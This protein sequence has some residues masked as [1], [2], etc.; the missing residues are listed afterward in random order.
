MARVLSITNIK[1]GVGKT[2]TAGNLAAA[3]AQRGRKV[4]AVDMDP[5]ASLTLSL[6]FQSDKLPRTMRHALDD[7]AVPLSSILLHTAEA[8]DL[9][10]ANHDL[11]RVTPLLERTRERLFSVRA[12]LA[13]V[14]DRYDYVLLDCPANAGVLTGAALVASDQ[15][16]VPLT[17]DFLSLRTLDWLLYIVD[18]IR[19]T[20]NPSL[21]IAGC[22]VTMYDPRPRHA[23]VVLDTLRT[24]YGA[25]MPVLATRIRYS[26]RLK[27]AAAIGQ[28]ILRYAPESEASE[29][30]RA[31][32]EELDEGIRPSVEN[33]LYFV[34]GR[35]KEAMT[36][37]DR[38][39]AFE[40]F[41]RATEIDPKM[42]V[43]WMGRA[44]NAAEWD[45]AS[46]AYA[47]VLQLEP[48][49]QEARVGLEKRLGRAILSADRASISALLALG[50]YLIE[51]GP[52]PYAERLF[53]RVTEL[54]PSHE[55]G[56]LGLARA[57]ADPREGLGYVRRCLEL[58]PASPRALAAQSEANERLR[59]EAR[60]LTEEAAAIARRGDKAAA[61]ALYEQAI[62]LDPRSEQGWLGLASAAPDMDSAYASVK[63]AL[64]LNPSSEQALEM[65]RLLWDPDRQG[66]VQQEEI[67]APPRRWLSVLLAI[68]V[69]AISLF[70][71]VR[72]LTQ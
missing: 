14:R 33:E 15:I 25:K 32:A 59:A 45:E 7:R 54:E 27:E 18:E 4:L 11:N 58:D 34:L 50:H 5:Q 38:R 21:S 63:K 23:R 49:H 56:W 24:T 47:R 72:V 16:L 1:G 19:E 36:K 46:R 51:M 10:P 65:Y 9:A 26:V 6:G 29:A 61:R 17:L 44:E 68:L 55:E 43:G 60:R 48:N 71:I 52:G 20:V 70:L 41:C 28:S 69:I 67:P 42:A 62:E 57:V 66:D 8:F 53:R 39:A 13:P 30:Y 3:L 12:A 31:L 2:T 35:A 37:Q 64:E 40:A 22:L